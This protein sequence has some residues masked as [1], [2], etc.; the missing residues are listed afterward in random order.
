M[1]V[2]LVGRR[3]IHVALAGGTLTAG[4]GWGT[5]TH[6]ARARE[7]DNVVFVEVTDMLL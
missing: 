4:V 6:V 7:T 1:R 3:N 2:A 5:D